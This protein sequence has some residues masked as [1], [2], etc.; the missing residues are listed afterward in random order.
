MHRNYSTHHQPKGSDDEKRQY[1]LPDLRGIISLSSL[2][3]MTYGEN[4]GHLGAGRFVFYEANSID[5]QEKARLFRPSPSYFPRCLR[6]ESRLF[7]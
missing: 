2:A 6:S 5:S 1:L 7:R 4:L 3:E